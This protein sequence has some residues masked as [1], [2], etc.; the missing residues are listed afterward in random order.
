MRR[1]Y[2]KGLSQYFKLERESASSALPSRSS[3][4]QTVR[5]GIGR[6]SSG[7][8]ICEAVGLRGRVNRRGWGRKLSETD[9]GHGVYE[10]NKL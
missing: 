9:P 1:L 6:R 8:G 5:G 7:T 2:A 3:G 4:L 10:K